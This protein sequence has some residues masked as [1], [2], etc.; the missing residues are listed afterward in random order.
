VQ[1]GGEDETEIE[2]KLFYSPGA[3]SLA[4][5]VAL[6]EIGAEFEL[7]KVSLADGENLAPDYLRINPRARVPALEIDGKLY[8][9]A[10]AL[11]VHIASLG[12][13]A[14]LLPPGATADH[15]RTLEWLA[16][17]SS[18]LHIAYACI[19][20]PER[21]LPAGA[22]SAP[23]VAYG[24]E[25]VA[26][27]NGE[28]EE[29]LSGPWFLGD[30]YGLADIYALPFFRWGN[31]IGLDMQAVCPRWA[32]WGVRM[33]DRPAVRDALGAEGMAAGDFLAGR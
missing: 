28:V 30:L 24:R 15:A 17:F 6:R 8:T 12:P 11:L 16:W 27:M 2:M 29:R 10:P 3:C 1:T 9:E 32:E 26:R 14:G 20:R 31:R 22:D 4:P 33:L 13:A 19:W 21:F 5:H 18:S 25:A 23:L 7:A